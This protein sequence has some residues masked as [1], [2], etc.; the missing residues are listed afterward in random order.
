M[1]D[2]QIPFTRSVSLARR[3]HHRCHR[4]GCFCTHKHAERRRISSCTY[5]CAFFLVPHV[6]HQY[7]V[8]IYICVY[9]HCN[10][11]LCIRCSVCCQNRTRG[12]RRC[13]IR[14]APSSLF[15]LGERVK[16]GGEGFKWA[17]VYTQHLYI[18]V[19]WVELC[20]VVV[21]VCVVE[22]E[23]WPCICALKCRMCAS[24]WRRSVPS[25]RTCEVGGSQRRRQ[26]R[27]LRQRQSMW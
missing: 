22:W 8:Y 6:R 1:M 15:Y 27:Q 23:R 17:H 16:K 7:H 19:L 20:F 26:L 24:M 3:Q 21:C 11:T 18:R 9:H 4:S 14:D 12:R 10:R 25:S 5:H 2:G 13:D